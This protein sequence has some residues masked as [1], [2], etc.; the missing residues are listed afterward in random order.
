MQKCHLVH[1]QHVIIVGAL[2]TEVGQS[3]E[4]TGRHQLPLDLLVT[5]GGDCEVGLLI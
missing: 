3:D 5:A 2:G 1:D 4:A